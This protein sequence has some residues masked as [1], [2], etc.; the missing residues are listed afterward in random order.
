M[1][2]TLFSALGVALQTVEITQSEVQGQSL[3]QS[4]D[5]QSQLRSI[6]GLQRQ[7]VILVDRLAILPPD[8]TTAVNLTKELDL[9]RPEL[10]TAQANLNHLEVLPLQDSSGQ[11]TFDRLASAFHWD[12]KILEIIVTL[13]VAAPTEDSAMVMAG[14]QPN[15]E[16][17]TRQRSGAPA[18]GKPKNPVPA[19][20]VPNA[21]ATSDGTPDP[22][23]EA[24]LKAALDHANA[25]KPLGREKVAQRLGISE[26]QARKLLEQLVRSGR[27]R[28]GTKSYQ[29]D[30]VTTPA[31][32][33]ASV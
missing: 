24:Y 21:S 29:V 18:E 19:P 22:T 11:G 27:V 7:I 5:Y 31:G 32:P 6:D 3:A 20:E 33:P 14:Y 13:V 10:T 9:L 16:P 25:P 28:V 8:Y 4:Q 12:R 15:P 26:P 2:L 17:D 30:G 23:P 1:F